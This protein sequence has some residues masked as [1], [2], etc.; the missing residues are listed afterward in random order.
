L[1]AGSNQR[2]AYRLLNE[3]SEFVQKEALHGFLKLLFTKD[4]AIG[5]IEGY[6]K[7]MGAA[8]ASFQASG[9]HRVCKL[10]KRPQISTDIFVDKHPRLAGEE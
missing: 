10:L 9:Y 2:R 8:I 6:N 7:R 4:E 3:I 1:L 5:R